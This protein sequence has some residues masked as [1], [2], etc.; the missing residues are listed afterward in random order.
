MATNPTPSTTEGKRI[1]W[2][3]PQCG[4]EFTRKQRFDAQRH[5]CVVVAPT[6]ERE[7]LNADAPALPRTQTATEPQS[8]VA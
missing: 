7:G 8:A 3:C 4:E 6:P 1:A 2:R 5:S